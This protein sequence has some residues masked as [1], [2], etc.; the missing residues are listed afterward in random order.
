MS[1]D[2]T[3][4]PTSRRLQEAR[5]KGQIARSKDLSDAAELLAILIVLG[6]FGPTFILRL[7]DAMRQGLSRMG[8][9]PDAGLD[10]GLLTGLAVDGMLT[11]CLLA[12]PFALASASTTLVVNVVQ[13]GW[14]IATQAL[15]LHWE[16]LGPMSGLKRLTGRMGLDLVKTLVAATVLVWIA[17]G[18]IELTLGE[19]SAYGRLEPIQAAV[20]GWTQ[21]ERL[22]RQS[23]I[24]L[25]LIAGAD[26][27]TQRWRHT[28]SLRMTKQEV[29]DDMRLIE[30]NP[31]VKARIRRLQREMIRRR[32]LAAVPKAT[33][34]ITNPTHYA[35]ALDYR[36][37]A[38]PAPRVVAK[39]RGHLAARIRALAREHEVPIVENV[40]LAQSLYRGVDVGEFIPAELF[41]A[42]A[43]VLA[44]LI[45]LKRLAL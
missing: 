2:R 31:Q 4:Q 28:R 42:V 44:Y 30:G 5:K 36:R 40:P 32:M 26:Y 34:V 12:G 7:G 25:A 19:A 41:G 43:E 45:R 35:V 20:R 38:M 3:E 33:V 11:I 27:L 15:G 9:G 39:G 6:W 18:S 14:N 10:A 17:W 22:L 29:K 1:S 21:A 24:A 23:V 13:G 37:E 16:R 8:G